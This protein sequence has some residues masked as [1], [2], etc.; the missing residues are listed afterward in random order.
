MHLN[1]ITK[2]LKGL[3]SIR[4]PI[5]VS[6]DG[7]GGA[8]KTSLARELRK[9]LD[10]KGIAAHLVHFDD[11]YRPSGE[12]TKQIRQSIGGEFD[13]R[14]LESQVLQPLRSHRPARY[15]VYDWALDRLDRR[16]SLLPKGVIL[17]EGV[18]TSRRELAEY[19]D[20]TIWVKCPLRICL[21][22]GVVRD[23]S[24][25]R[26][27]WIEWLHQESRYIRSHCPYQRADFVVDGT[28]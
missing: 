9:R 19:Y 14:R 12:R 3:S 4:A 7:H 20:L 15:R 27:R 25:S 11:F 21:G 28:S 5:I 16:E 6:I 18:Y 8:G 2:R 17:V 13:W 22:R 26:Q 1:A 23:Q 10:R 24:A